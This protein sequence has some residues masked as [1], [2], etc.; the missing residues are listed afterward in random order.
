MHGGN[1]HAIQRQTGIQIS[2]LLDFSANINPLGIPNAL[3]EIMK[4]SL[5][6]SVHYPDPDY[7][8]LYESMA[9]FFQCDQDRLVI[10]NGAAHV[11]H[12]LLTLLQPQKVL[13]MAPTF[14]E[15]RQALEKC[16]T[17][18]IT[19][20]LSSEETFDL[21]LDQLEKQLQ[22]GIN[23]L[24]LCNPNNPTGRLIS[25]SQMKQVLAMCRDHR[26]R[27]LVDEAFIDFTTNES[28]DSLVKETAHWQELMVIRA[29]T[30]IFAI[31]GIRLGAAV[32]GDVNLASRVRTHLVPWSVNAVAES[33][34][35]FLNTQ[36]AANYLSRSV[37]LVTAEREWIFSK[38]QK[39]AGLKPV[40]GSANYLLVALDESAP[41]VEALQQY[42][43]QHGIM[44]RNCSNYEGL[45]HHWFRV[46]VRRREE[47]QKLIDHLNCFLTQNAQN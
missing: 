7:H 8:R 28:I 17:T 33:M 5:E 38:L 41:P 22:Q 3:L 44:I 35:D 1:V 21:S 13:L 4:A 2:T 24:I 42:L 40:P 45:H 46:A 26:C 47:N 18:I 20:S 23:L 15:Y 11:I 14:S 10:G 6:E 19:L 43:L 12:E 30:K 25:I 37:A 16:D 9:R 32:L 39:I 27:L 29:F 34:A 36:E 31:P